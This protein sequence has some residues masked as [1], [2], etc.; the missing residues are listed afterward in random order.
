MATIK[1]SRR[2]P[3]KP[4]KLVWRISERAPLGQWVDPSAK[5]A[6]RSPAG[7]P[8]VL[9]GG[10]WLASSF[11]LLSGLDVSEGRATVPV[12]L[13]DELFPPIKSAPKTQK[14]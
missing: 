12:D 7:L 14:W 2:T 1:S 10:E 9:T 6:G 3:A 13:F 4:Q 5:A 8:E 11:D